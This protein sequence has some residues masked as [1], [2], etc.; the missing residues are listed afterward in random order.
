[1]YSSDGPEKDGEKTIQK[2]ISVEKCHQETCAYE[3]NPLMRV[4]R[5]NN[6]PQ[7]LL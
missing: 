1:M 5:A 7:A 6:P 3:S 4:N 2:A